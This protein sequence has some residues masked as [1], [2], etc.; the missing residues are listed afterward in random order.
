MKGREE[1]AVFLKLLPADL[2]GWASFTFGRP[3][4]AGVLAMSWSV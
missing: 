4:K 2:R 3:G 1:N